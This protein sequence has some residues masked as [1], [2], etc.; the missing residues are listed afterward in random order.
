MIA[1]VDS[2]GVVDRIG[3]EAH[4]MSARF[5]TAELGEPEIATLAHDLAAQGVAVDAHGVV[6]L[7]AHVR[8]GL[9]LRLHIGADAAVPEQVDGRG[10]DAL[11][12]LGRRERARG[13][14][15]TAEP[16]QLRAGAS[17]PRRAGQAVEG[18]GRGRKRIWYL[19]QAILAKRNGSSSLWCNKI[20]VRTTFP[21]LNICRTYRCGGV[22]S[23]GKGGSRV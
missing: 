19:M 12:E 13:R 4:A 9:R 18:R 20:K 8:V 14:S 11:D 23:E 21:K 17:G 7:V 3:I 10:E 16:G 2:C 5:D 15:A 22:L 6:G 1:A